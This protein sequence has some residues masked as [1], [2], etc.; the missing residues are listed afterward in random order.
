MTKETH[1][2]Q[3]HGNFER[4]DIG[5]GGVLYF[6]LGL[7][8]FGLITHFLITALYSY[9]QKRSEA[10]QAPVNALVKN[11]PADT[12][13]LSVD[14]RDY[15]KQNFPTPQLEIDERNQLDKIRLDEEQT[16][17]SYDYIDKTAGT[18]RIPIEHAMDLI[19]Q[20]GLPVR[21]QNSTETTASPNSNKKKG[22][23][24]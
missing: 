17:N 15:L 20:R 10:E 5:V 21:G 1:H 14:Y 3:G 23:K 2:A 24:Q 9:L 22:S 8:V 19:A 6:L 11:A 7:A 13:H 16:L 12:R 4:R 18:V